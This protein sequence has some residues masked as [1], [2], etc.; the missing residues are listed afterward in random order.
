MMN[1]RWQRAPQ[2]GNE[3]AGEMNC[4]ALRIGRNLLLALALTLSL[5]ASMRADDAASVYKAKCASCHGPKGKKNVGTHDFASPEVQKMT[6]ADL[7]GII[8]TGKNS[9]PGY[10][11]S[12]KEPE[13]K[14]QVAYVRE[15]AK[16]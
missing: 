11:K 3:E 16:K 14:D 2:F 4:L 8:S 9:M 5:S 15:L 10:A 7:T 13:I 6:D 1:E 12:L